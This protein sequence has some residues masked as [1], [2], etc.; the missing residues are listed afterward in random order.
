MNINTNES[1]IILGCGLSGMLTSLSLAH[2]GIPS[3]ILEKKTAAELENPNDPRTTSLNDSS[4]NFMSRIMV[5]DGLK[6]FAQPIKDIYVCQN[7]TN[8][9]FHFPLLVN[10]KYLSLIHI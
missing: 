6:S 2:E 9:V 1:I 3:V 8:N 10:V 5:W 7:M 4:I